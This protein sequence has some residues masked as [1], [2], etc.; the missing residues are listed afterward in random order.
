MAT[1]FKRSSTEKTI[2]LFLLAFFARYAA[3]LPSV[4]GMICTSKFGA[5]AISFSV[6]VGFEN[7]L[8]RVTELLPITIL[9]HPKVLQIRRFDKKH[10]HRTRFRFWHPAVPQ[11]A[12]CSAVAL[13]L[14]RTLPDNQGF[15]QTAR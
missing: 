1:L 6:R 3:F 9:K 10:L 13:H 7:M 2:L 14:P 11:D 12:Y 5:F 15:Q 8:F 4:S